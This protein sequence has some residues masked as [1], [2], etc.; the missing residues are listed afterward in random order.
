VQIFGCFCFIKLGKLFVFPRAI[1]LFSSPFSLYWALSTPV[2]HG[3]RFLFFLAIHLVFFSQE[4]SLAA[5][6]FIFFIKLFSLRTLLVSFFRPFARAYS[7]SY[8]YV[9][10]L[11]LLSIFLRNASH[12][13]HSDHD[14]SGSLPLQFRLL[15]T[16]KLRLESGC[17]RNP[18]LN[19]SLKILNCFPVFIKARASLFKLGLYNRTPAT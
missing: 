8:S 5:S 19:S 4:Q 18:N 3:R 2:S 13:P 7:F 11:H 10:S 12:L 6:R 15:F 14:S 16:H 1:I 9:L 17:Q